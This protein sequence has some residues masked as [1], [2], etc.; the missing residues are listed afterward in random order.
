MNMKFTE[1]MK[2]RDAQYREI[3]LFQSMVLPNCKRIRE[4][5]SSGERTIDEF[6]HLL[7]HSEK[8]REFIAEQ[9]PDRKLVESYYSEVTRGSWVDKLPSKS[10]RFVVANGLGIA[11]DAAFGAGLAT[12]AVQLGYNVL[13]TFILEKILKGWRPNRFIDD[14]LAPFLTGTGKK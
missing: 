3:D 11:V 8:F 10:T 5:I 1:L 2:K 12:A 4:V 9:N 14:E 7:D 13:D 6:L